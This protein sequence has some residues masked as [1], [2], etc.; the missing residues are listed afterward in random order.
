MGVHKR[1]IIHEVK[2]G[3]N[4]SMDYTLMFDLTLDFIDFPPPLFSQFIKF[5]RA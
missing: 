1:K 3:V 2:N 5:Y 4:K